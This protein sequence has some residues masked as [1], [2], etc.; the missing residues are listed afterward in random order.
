ME[1]KQIINKNALGYSID[2]INLKQN[3]EN[4]EN[5]LLDLNYKIEQLKL[6]ISAV[7]FEYENK[8]GKLYIKLDKINVYVKI[9]DQIILLVNN[10]IDYNKAKNSMEELFKEQIEILDKQ[11]NEI[12]EE[13]YQYNTVSKEKLDELKQIW[14]KLSRKFHPDIINGNEK[15]MQ[16]INEAYS[17]KDLDAL[18]QIENMEYVTN[19]S[20]T[21]IDNMNIRY[22]KLCKAIELFK[23]NYNTLKNTEW[24]KLKLDID[25]S[26]SN[27]I[28]LLNELSKKILLEIVE[29]ENNIKEIKRKYE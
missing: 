10:G 29:K 27:N 8:I 24:A 5:E 7:K 3:I 13:N 1:E 20:R 15:I 2:E 11:V 16:Q 22:D 21:S 23:E 28:D 19:E 6:D 18:K 12:N 26:K 4:K 25:N 9:Y 14:K 17:N